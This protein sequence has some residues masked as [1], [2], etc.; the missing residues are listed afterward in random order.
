[1]RLAVISDVLPSTLT[2]TDGVLAVHG[3]P[4][5]DVE[6]LLEEKVDGRLG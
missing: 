6:Y 2:V 3:T 4:A 1:V 5:S